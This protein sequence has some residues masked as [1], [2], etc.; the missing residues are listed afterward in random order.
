MKTNLVTIFTSAIL[1]TFACNRAIKEYYPNG[2]LKSET[3]HIKGNK[4][5]LR[6][7]NLDQ[8]LVAEYEIMDSLKSGTGKHYKNGQL[9]FTSTWIDGNQSAYIIDNSG[10]NKIIVDHTLPDTVVTKERVK[11]KIFST[12]KQWKIKEAYFFCPIGSDGIFRIRRRHEHECGRFVVKD[13][14]VLIEFTAAGPGLKNFPLTTIL[15]ENS[16]G[17]IQGK[18]FDLKYYIKKTQAN[19]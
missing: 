3:I 15:F 5:L 6:E 8:Q 11:G 7:Y 9:D 19:N 1:L 16:L 4:K 2:E 14:A 13:N 10:N 17:L 12:N 18:E